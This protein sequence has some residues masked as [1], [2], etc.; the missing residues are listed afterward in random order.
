MNNTPNTHTDTS[1]QERMVPPS[2]HNSFAQN[3]LGQ[4]IQ[5]KTM[6]TH[7]PRLSL[8]S[9]SIV[10]IATTL[11]WAF[12]HFSFCFLLQISELVAPFLLI[13]GVGWTMVPYAFSV[14]NKT[15]S[16]TTSDAQTQELVQHISQSIPMDLTIAG[17]HLTPHILIS[18][19]LLLMAL[20]AVCATAGAWLGRRL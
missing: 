11:L 4:K 14:A 6:S 1:S 5:Q 3:T 7:R 9:E 17:H 13:I 19:G 16:G 20:A 18:Y 12:F 8:S 15:I 10:K 2:H